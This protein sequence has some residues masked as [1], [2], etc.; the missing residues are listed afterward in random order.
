MLDIHECPSKVDLE[1][2]RNSNLLISKCIQTEK[3][4]ANNSTACNAPGK[5]ILKYPHPN[6]NVN[7]ARD[8][9]E[10]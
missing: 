2:S 1:L 6:S 4:H 8:R 9:R 7:L 10:K 5:Y 3:E